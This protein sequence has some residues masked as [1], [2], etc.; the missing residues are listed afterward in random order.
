MRNGFSFLHVQ[1]RVRCAR[2]GD[3]LRGSAGHGPASVRPARPTRSGL[4]SAGRLACSAFGLSRRPASWR[5]GPSV[6]PFGSG[7]PPPCGG[8]GVPSPSAAGS[9]SLCSASSRGGF[10]RPALVR[11]GPSRGGV[12]CRRR[13]GPF[14]YRS[15]S[16]RCPSRAPRV[17]RAFWPVAAGR[18][19]SPATGNPFRVRPRQARPHQK[20]VSR[21][22]KSG[23]GGCVV[24]GWGAGGPFGA[25]NCLPSGQGAALDNVER[26]CP[27]KFTPGERPACHSFAKVDSDTFV[28]QQLLP[29]CL[30]QRGA[31]V[32]YRFFKGIEHEQFGRVQAKKTGKR[33]ASPSQGPRK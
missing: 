13:R 31:E 22:P 17:S 16:L 30:F 11:A 25:R 23:S 19:T 9:A 33:D 24:D 21:L 5:V 18:T 8:S 12:G 2:N 27:R 20:R 10:C 26:H 32:V 28:L 1:L 14:P 15:A 7:P 4:L 6:R 3:E 29:P